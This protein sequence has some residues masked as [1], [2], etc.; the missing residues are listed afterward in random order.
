MLTMALWLL[1][2]AFSSFFFDV[3]GVKVIEIPLSEHSD[4]VKSGETR[5]TRR[6][7]S[8][9][10]WTGE[11]VKFRLTHS[12]HP[13]EAASAKENENAA[14][15]E[16]DDAAGKQHSRKSSGRE[17]YVI[18]QRWTRRRRELRE[19]TSDAAKD[20]SGT[21]NPAE[22]SST[23]GS[24]SLQSSRILKSQQFLQNKH[25]SLFGLDSDG[26]VEKLLAGQFAVDIL[27]GRSEADDDTIEEGESRE[28][29]ASRQKEKNRRKLQLS[30]TGSPLPEF[31]HLEIPIGQLNLDI[32]VGKNRE[33]VR[34]NAKHVLTDG[35]APKHWNYR[36]D[37][38][39]MKNQEAKVK[40]KEMLLQTRS[41]QTRSLQTRS[42]KNRGIKD[43]VNLSDEK[44]ISEENG[45]L[46]ISEEKLEEMNLS[47]SNPLPLT[48]KILDETIAKFRQDLKGQLED[49]SEKNNKNN[50]KDD[51]VIFDNSSQEAFGIALD[52]DFALS[53]ENGQLYRENCWYIGT[54]LTEKKEI[55]GGTTQISGS[56]AVN[57]CRNQQGV[58]G[59]VTTPTAGKDY[60]VNAD[61]Y[62]NT[63]DG[64]RVGLKVKPT[65]DDDDGAVV[66]K[67]GAV[68]RDIRAAR[69][70]YTVRLLSDTEVQAQIQTLKD[71]VNP[72]SGTLSDSMGSVEDAMS[73]ES[74]SE[75][76]ANGE[77]PLSFK[78]EDGA[79]N[80]SEDDLDELWVV[81]TNISAELNDTTGFV[82]DHAQ[83]DESSTPPVIDI[84]HVSDVSNI[85]HQPRALQ[86]PIGGTEFEISGGV[87]KAE[88]GEIPIG[89]GP[90]SGNPFAERSRNMKTVGVVM[91]S[92]SR[93]SLSMKDQQTSSGKQPTVSAS[94]LS[95]PKKQI[96]LRH[97]YETAED[98]YKERRELSQ[99]RGE[100]RSLKVI[101]RKKYVEV[102][103]IND[104]A[105]YES[106]T[107][108]NDL[109]NH[110]LQVWEFCF[111]SGMRLLFAVE[112]ITFVLVISCFQVLG[113]IRC[114]FDFRFMIW[115]C[116]HKIQK[117]LSGR[118]YRLRLI[119]IRRWSQRSISEMV[120]HCCRR[121]LHLPA[122][123]AV[124]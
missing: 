122:Y 97:L 49:K 61:I 52:T 87:R 31:L 54:V 98:V 95:P 68:R 53:H 6:R 25:S 44:H 19:N 10:H 85:G 38:N 117:Q 47:E 15:K 63:P 123:G 39:W 62:L 121:H 112:F 74:G 79:R 42:L 119:S 16:K 50:N 110:C 37:S 104:H 107:H 40:Q 46:T 99:V 88:S 17:T 58:N 8:Y 2:I 24:S 21:S 116:I 36:S 13:N 94:Q 106:F 108:T 77:F 118:Q 67:K 83:N 80:L 91:D 41:L 105:R 124:V 76:S 113:S 84:P 9:S 82:D 32:R 20:T 57:A 22:N 86:V 35:N 7:P 30:P 23:E 100:N 28:E 45:R 14:D 3:D 33:L 111:S 18:G 109:T 69:P 59:G 65:I 29:D 114:R 55:S 93:R 115:F 11:H 4:A 43:L 48:R 1:S 12:S 103:L 73:S 34:N 64:G 75:P 5:T 90:L 71:Y 51:D 81:E 101:N 26:E 78:T 27:H 56:V 120:I 70:D 102:L 96:K 92:K 89:N 72:R 60:F 66:D